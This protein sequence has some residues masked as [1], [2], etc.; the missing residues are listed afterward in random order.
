MW[1]EYACNDEKFLRKARWNLSN[2]RAETMAADQRHRRPEDAPRPV[3]SSP[4]VQIVDL[5]TLLHPA[6]DL[7]LT[8][9]SKSSSSRSAPPA[10]HNALQSLEQQRSAE[11]GLERRRKPSQQVWSGT[12]SNIDLNIVELPA[13]GPS[14]PN[15]S[16]RQPGIHAMYGKRQVRAVAIQRAVVPRLSLM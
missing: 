7:R 3:F 8:S 16:T 15:P 11:R 6:I 10:H 5:S 1:Q 12:F 4:H 14:T 9:E 13:T 2:N